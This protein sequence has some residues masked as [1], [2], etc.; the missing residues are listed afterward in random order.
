MPPSDTGKGSAQFTGELPAESARIGH[1]LVIHVHSVG[2]YNPRV[3]VTGKT[4]DSQ[5]WSP[6]IPGSAGRRTDQ[7]GVAIQV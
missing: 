2:Q 4:R 1:G 7:T 5:G 3:P 6:A